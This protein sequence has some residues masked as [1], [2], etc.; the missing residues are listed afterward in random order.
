MSDPF[1]AQGHCP[2]DPCGFF[3]EEVPGGYRWTCRTDGHT[4]GPFAT[5]EEAVA[6]AEAYCPT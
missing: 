3:I 2:A 5:R 4:E 6:S 1:D